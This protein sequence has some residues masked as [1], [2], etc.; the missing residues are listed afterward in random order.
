[1]ARGDRTIKI[2]RRLGKKRYLQGKYLYAH[3][4]IYVPVPSRFHNMVKPL[5]NQR[6]KIDITNKNDGLVIA[7][8]P[9][10]TPRKRFCMPNSPRR[11]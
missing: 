5:L 1:M 10:S 4:R 7:L 2:Y 8:H 9:A 3:E 6:L 11:K